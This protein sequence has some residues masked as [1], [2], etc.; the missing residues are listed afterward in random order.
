MRKYFLLIIFVELFVF[1]KAQS[2]FKIGVNYVFGGSTYYGAKAN[3]THM[4]GT[5]LP[6]YSIKSS[7]GTGV[8][9]LY[10][11]KEKWGVNLALS[12]Q[13]RGAIFDKGI[14]SYNPRY[15]FNYA[16]INLGVS[17]QTKEIFKNSR[18][19]FNISGIYSRLLNSQRVN[20]YESYNLIDDSEPGDFGALASVGLNICRLER[21]VIQISIFGNTGFKNVF[22]GVLAENGQTGKNLLFGLQL[23]YLFGFNKK[24]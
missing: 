1:G 3:S 17:F 23:G 21:D 16:D 19:C 11:F 8:K 6:I 13:Q 18:L 10:I 7:N 2:G 14:Y 9:L 20:N 5:E 22:A 15:R 24:Q 4:N 12:Y